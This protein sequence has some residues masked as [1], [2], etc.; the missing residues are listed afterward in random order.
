ME[1]RESFQQ[2]ALRKLDNYLYKKEIRMFLYAVYK[3]KLKLD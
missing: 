1:K 2:L 3:N